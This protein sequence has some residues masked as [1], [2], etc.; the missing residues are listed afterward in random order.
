MTCM[1]YK[2]SP[3]LLTYLDL[4]V[5]NRFSSP[6]TTVVAKWRVVN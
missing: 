2:L 1:E 4:S 3:E 5:P 6:I